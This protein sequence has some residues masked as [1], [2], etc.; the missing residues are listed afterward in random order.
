MTTNRPYRQGLSLD[1]AFEE[2]RKYSGSQFDPEIVDAFFAA[3][4]M[5]AFFA[6]NSRQKIIL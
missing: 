4:V 1:E 2:L 6:A 5:E 3:D